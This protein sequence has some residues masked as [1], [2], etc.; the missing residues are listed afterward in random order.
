MANS[1]YYSY[2]FISI[3]MAS[4]VGTTMRFL[5]IRHNLFPHTHMRRVDLK[6]TFGVRRKTKH[7]FPTHPSFEH[8]EDDYYTRMRLRNAG[9]SQETIEEIMRVMH[10]C[11][12]EFCDERTECVPISASAP[13]DEKEQTEVDRLTKI[14][15]EHAKRNG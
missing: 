8:H 14:A 15:E 13:L 12:F 6:T 10:H 2:W 9:Y 3:E 7:N 5:H 1:L 11:P 4:R